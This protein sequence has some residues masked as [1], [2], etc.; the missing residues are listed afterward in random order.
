[1]DV[2]TSVFS[3]E[4]VLF[5]ET[6]LVKRNV[7]P[8]SKHAA[9]LKGFHDTLHACHRPIMQPIMYETA[10]TVARVFVFEWILKGG[11]DAIISD[12]G[13]N[14]MSELRVQ[15]CKYLNITK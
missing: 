6:K 10:E 5:S 3:I 11:A 13:T 15:V 14:F 2:S 9:V 1:M 12:Q 8:E 7:L 4:G